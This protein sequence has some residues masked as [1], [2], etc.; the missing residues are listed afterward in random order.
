MTSAR[1]TARMSKRPSSGYDSRSDH[2]PDPGQLRR[3]RPDLAALADEDDAERRVIGEAPLDEPPVARLEDVERQ[4]DPRTE[5]R[6]EREEGQVHRRASL[7]RVARP[8]LR[9][10]LDRSTARPTRCAAGGRPGGQE[11]A[12]G[13]RNRRLGVFDG[14]GPRPGRR[15]DQCEQE[16]AVPA[17]S[18][19]RKLEPQPQAATAFGLLTVKPAPISVST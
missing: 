8:P 17:S 2:R 14:G 7:V 16:R 1:S 13:R 19:V 9:S 12:A 5:D 3:Y 4:G 11:E 18:A 6:V 10:G 15:M